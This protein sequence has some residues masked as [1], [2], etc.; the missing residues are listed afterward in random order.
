MAGRPS[1]FTEAVVGKLEEIFS[2][3]GTVEEACFYA[4]ISRDT[5][6][7]HIKQKPEL[8]DRFEALRLNP[9][10]AARRT[11][12]KRLADNYQNAMDYLARKRKAEFTPRQEVT[13]ANGEPLFTDEHKDK[14]TAAIRQ[15]TR[16]GDTDA[17]K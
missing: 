3:D 9:V 13:G 6:Y 15:I 7:E 16:R 4:G 2:L 14:A 12:V 5:Y 8:A 11:V 17:G 1:K 10:L